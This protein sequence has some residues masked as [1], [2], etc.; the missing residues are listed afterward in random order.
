[1]FIIVYRIASVL[2]HLRAPL[3]DV[4]LHMLFCA[5]NSTKWEIIVIVIV[6]VIVILYYIIYYCYC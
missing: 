4:T 5:I 1:L 3:C 6:I 2:V